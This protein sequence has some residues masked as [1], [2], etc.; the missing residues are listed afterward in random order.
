MPKMAILASKWSFERGLLNFE[1]GLLGV[2]GKTSD[3]KILL[4]EKD[5]A[6]CLAIDLFCH[7]IVKTAGTHLKPGEKR[8]ITAP[9]LLPKYLPSVQ[10]KIPLHRARSSLSLTLYE[11]SENLFFFFRI[12]LVAVKLQAH[13]QKLIHEKDLR[14]IDV[15]EIQKG[16]QSTSIL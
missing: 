2:S 1:S 14:E 9:L 11:V 8:A 13:C 4:K 5:P 15:T 16:I 12:E 7:R 6:C 3:V 10:M